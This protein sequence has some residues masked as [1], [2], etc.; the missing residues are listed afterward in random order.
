MCVVRLHTWHSGPTCFVN[1][2][3]DVSQAMKIDD[4]FHQKAILVCIDELTSRPSSI[5]VSLPLVTTLIGS[6]G[7]A[8]SLLCVSGQ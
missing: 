5:D 1:L 6:L 2:T 3:V 4:E 7:G 8:V